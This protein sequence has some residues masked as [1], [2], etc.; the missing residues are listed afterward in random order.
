MDE[1]TFYRLRTLFDEIVGLAPEQRV[2][3]IA[4][5]NDLDE[6]TRQ[7]LLDLLDID[8]EVADLT[9]RN[10]IPSANSAATL[11][12]G[13][14]I[15]AYVIDSPLGEGG[16]GSVYRARRAGADIEQWVAIKVARRELLDQGT[17]ARFRVERQVLAL[18]QHAQIAA[19]YDVGELADGTPYIVMEYV[20]GRPLLEDADARQ[21][22][23]RERLEIFLLLC[24]AVS[25][26]HRN[27]IVHRDIKSSNV[28]VTADGRPKLLDFGIAK[29]LNSKLGAV[30]IEQTLTSERFFS[31]RN[32]APEQWR[33][34]AV[35]VTCDVYGLG[36]VLYELLCKRPLY[37]F[38]GMTFAQMERCIAED[39]PEPPSRRVE[40][41]DA[42]PSWRRKLSRDLD[43]VAL[44]ALRRSPKLRYP[45][46]DAFADDVRRFLR[47][48][49][50]AA[51]EAPLRY[52]AGKFLRRHRVI[53]T[54]VSLLIMLAAFGA[55]VWL[56]QYSST[57]AERYRAEAVS[58]M[59]IGSVN[60]LAPYG[61]GRDQAGTDELFDR[62]SRFPALGTPTEQHAS[63]VYLATTTA[64]LQ[65]SLGNSDYAVQTLFRAQDDVR[66]VPDDLKEAFDT[67]MASALIASKE[68]GRAKPIIAKYTS[69]GARGETAIR[70]RLIDA[71][72]AAERREHARVV[73]LLEP[74]IASQSQATPEQ[75]LEGRLRRARALV[76]SGRHEA[77]IVSMHL[78]V[79]LQETRPVT[80]M[81]YLATLRVAEEVATEAEDFDTAL[82]FSNKIMKECRKNYRGEDPY[83]NESAIR[84][85]SALAD[86]GQFNAAEE[87]IFAALERVW[88]KPS[89]DRKMVARLQI[90]RGE[91]QRR[92][93]PGAAIAQLSNA[94]EFG[95][96]IL[97][98]YDA[99]G[100][101]GTAALLLAL[102]E[103]DYRSG[104]RSVINENNGLLYV[105]PQ[106]EPLGAD[107]SRSKNTLLVG[108]PSSRALAIYKL[109]VRIYRKDDFVRYG[110]GVD[111]ETSLAR[112]DRNGMD[113]ATRVL[114]DDAA[115][116]V[117][118]RSPRTYPWL[119][120]Q[121]WILPRETSR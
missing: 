82:H 76:L 119:R 18:L 93:V 65:L 104:A 117:R 19:M 118:E 8:A 5:R 40:I 87:S 50:V 100:L 16:M 4:R 68:V 88:S 72:A 30:A 75:V 120:H 102:L 113:R 84:H 61:L 58:R 83:C 15:G 27:L 97:D 112:T 24:D 77:A 101:R 23:L 6:R 46:V 107:G 39:D 70:W 33:G 54:S 21:L 20:Q 35:D 48:Y 44:H 98:T 105:S 94:I 36:S 91:I 73:E 110:C 28:L 115:T 38:D 63:R 57:L 111:V 95:E 69:T 10:A 79:N 90:A 13:T 43:A 66:H 17:L 3:A 37:D 14:R 47:G 9:A 55:A 34:D 71:A 99:D 45:S 92:R 29:P 22:G 74:V 1:I 52:R 78:A 81:Q 86:A 109:L 60:E 116:Y 103:W 59:M 25:Y 7:R 62:F 2:A 53:V 49:P 56:R 89:V 121:T 108:S 31:P 12:A 80:R 106:V 26:A 96:P 42:T 11:R 41:D 114:Y 67:A 32:V 64:Q 51:R 85:A